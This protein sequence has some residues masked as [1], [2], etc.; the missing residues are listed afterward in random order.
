VAGSPGE[1]DADCL[2]SEAYSVYIAALSEGVGEVL[3][4]KW[5]ELVNDASVLVN[6]TVSR[7]QS[8]WWWLV[9]CGGGGDDAGDDDDDDDDDDDNDDDGE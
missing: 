5:R 7:R 3:R 8:W 9:W 2:D 4:G 1:D 6:G